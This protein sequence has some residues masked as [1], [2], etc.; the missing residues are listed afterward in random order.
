MGRLQKIRTNIT[1]FLTLQKKNLVIIAL[2]LSI[3]GLCSAGIEYLIFGYV[4]R[5]LAPS[6]QG[7][8]A[9]SKDAITGQDFHIDERGNL[10]SDKENATLSVQTNSHPIESLLIELPEHPAEYGV[11]VSYTDPKTGQNIILKKVLTRSLTKDGYDFLRSLDF[12]VRNSPE[13]IIIHTQNP[14]TIITG[15]TIDNTYHFNTHRFVFLW[16]TSIV[17]VFLFLFRKKIGTYPEWA[18]LVIAL[19]CG[20]LLSFSE[21]RTYVSWD[22]LI[23]YKR[24]DELSLKKIFP[25]RVNDVYATVSS[26]PF[27]HSSNEQRVID[28][29]LDNDF[30]KPVKKRGDTSTHP[31][32]LQNFFSLYTQIPYI[33]SGL[34]LFFGRLIHLPAHIIFMLG[35]FVNIVV[36]SLL[37]FFAIRRLKTGKMILAT[38]ALLPTSVFLASNYNYDSWLTGFTLLGL[39]YLFS[40]LQEP[41]Y[42]LSR[43]DTIIMI[44]VLIIGCAAKAIYFPLLLLLFLLKPVHF[45]SFKEYRVFLWSNILA[46]LF[47]VSSFVLPFLSSGSAYTDQRGGSDVN[48]VSQVHFILSHPVEYTGT[49]TRFIGNYINPMNWSYLTISFAYLGNI[50]GF[51]LILFILT[52]VTLTDKNRYDKKTATLKTHFWVIAITFGT[53]ALLATS[54][55]VSF[56]PVGLATINGVQKRYLLP[57]L[58]PVLFILGPSRFK[59]TLNRNLYNT[60]IFSLIAIILLRGIW[61]LIISLYY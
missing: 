14:G 30:K 55:Y 44:G 10:I 2:T 15:I 25:K 24:A 39:A 40:A 51:S 46:V 1:T 61:D 7:I 34:T 3:L 49:L 47:V 58:F 53:I 4:L 50:R 13:S 32:T 20:A 52:L 16:A 48:A 18:F 37:G 9:L 6:E 54:L 57:L 21:Q 33:P 12:L 29:Y 28:T 22:E 5:S 11:S 17:I 43:R 8:T 42:I 26:I 45:P 36:F 19:V 41:D 31:M 56:T 59:N 35:R 60:V 27:S 38:I 23:H